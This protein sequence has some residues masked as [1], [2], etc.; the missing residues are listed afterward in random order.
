MQSPRRCRAPADAELQQMQSSSRC[1]APADADTDTDP[2]DKDRCITSARDPAR[3]SGGSMAISRPLSAQGKTSPQEVQQQN[4]RRSR[5]ITC[6]WAPK[7]FTLRQLSSGRIANLDADPF[8]R[9]HFFTLRN[10]LQFV[11]FLDCQR[12]RHRPT[13]QL[14]SFGHC[15]RL[16]V[17]C[18]VK[19]AK[20]VR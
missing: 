11:C 9:R 6:A 17:A 4:I 19:F 7:W 15:V 20:T 5:S 18:W 8:R 2:A 14:R 1:R 16:P 3:L 12:N 10:F 13:R